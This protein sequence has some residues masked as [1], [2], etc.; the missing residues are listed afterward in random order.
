[1]GVMGKWVFF[2]IVII[3]FWFNFS[4]I[5]ANDNSKVSHWSITKTKTIKTPI[6]P[7]HPVKLTATT[8]KFPENEH[9]PGI[10]RF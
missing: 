6:H 10:Q 4:L 9:T 7:A 5:G 1:M 8:R 3:L 2:L